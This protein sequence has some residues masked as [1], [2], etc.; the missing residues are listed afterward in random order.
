MRRKKRI[1]MALIIPAL[2]LIALF[3][4]I[5]LV[6]AVRISF[7]KWNGYSQRMKYIGFDNYINAFSDKMFWKTFK[8]TMIYGFG[9]CLLQNI[10]GLLAALYLNRQ[11]RGRNMMRVIL[12]MPIMISGFLMGRILYYFVQLDGGAW[13]EIL[14]WFGLEPVYWMKTGDSAVLIITLVNSWQYMGLCMLIYLAGLQNIPTMYYEAARL[15]GANSLQEF[16]HVT[17]PMLSPAITTAVVTN[18]IGGF[19]MYDVIVS[20]S[21]GGPS[22]GSMSLSYYVSELYF[23]DEKAGYSSAVGILLFLAIIIITVPINH[24]LKKRTVEY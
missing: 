23:T 7:F 15:D 9:S 12:Y 20:L 17:F 13:N 14:G 8:N 2:I 1:Q 11:F 24:A 16:A 5:P 6:N 19:K 21:S 3:V 18:L 10:C 22:R 4:A